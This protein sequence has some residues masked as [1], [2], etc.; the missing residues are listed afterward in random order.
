M[1]I[2]IEKRVTCDNCGEACEHQALESEDPREIAHSEG[3]VTV[4]G[5]DLCPVC[6]RGRTLHPYEHDCDRCI[7]VGWIHIKGGGKWGSDW[8]NMY[9]CPPENPDV[10][11]GSVVIRFSDEPS[12]YWSSPIGACSKGPLAPYSA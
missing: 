5:K 9:F 1:G 4:D 7:W 11:R 8:G 6:S 12:D 2:A 10:S 3:F